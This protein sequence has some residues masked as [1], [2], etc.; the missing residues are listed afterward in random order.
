M[1]KEVVN[2]LIEAAKQAGYTESAIFSVDAPP[3]SEM[4]DFATNIALTISSTQKSDPREVAQKIIAELDRQKM[5]TKVEMAG[6]GFINLTLKNDLYLSELKKI[7]DQKV[8]YGKAE[9]T[10]ETINVEYISAN[11][12]GPLHIGNARSGPLGEAIANILEFT[13]HSVIREFYVNDIGVQIGRFGQSLYHWYA[14]KSDPNVTFPEGGYPGEYIKETSEKIQNEFAQEILDLKD[15]KGRIEFFAKK[16]LEIMV[17]GIKADANLLNIKFDRWSYE[18][19]ILK[20]GKS[21]KIVLELKEKK[22]TAEKDGAV[23]F[24]R[25]DDPELEDRDAVLIKSDENKS[26]TYFANDLA[27]HVDKLTRSEKA[28]DVWGANH[29]GHI[30]RVKS[31]L[32]ALGYKDRVEIIL[33]QYV[34]LRSSGKSMS[35]GKRLG[36]FVTLRAVLESGVE[37]DAFKY[38]ILSQN[39]NTPFDFDIDLAADTSEKNPVFYIKYAHARICSILKKVERGME[40]ENADLS[41]L[42]DPKEIALYKEICKFPELVQEVAMDFQVQAIPHFAYRIATLFHDFYS[43]CQVIGTEKELED[44]RL[45]LIIATKYVIHN[46]L[47]LS[48]IEAP[49][50]M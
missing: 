18:S 31:A 13:G 19:E 24:T 41:L 5:Y 35:M 10:G 15:E 16:G 49:E 44:A 30:P 4:G 21:Q 43:S 14:I 46:A 39:P 29:F 12:T 38:F 9:P 20:S 7:L 23:W 50:K 2:S 27:Y 28:I 45:A 36:N 22:L 48:G 3:K 37:A 26:L 17:E 47:G 1:K 32:E 8:N 34:R 42:Q 11:P 33:Y 40:N 25:P 6:P